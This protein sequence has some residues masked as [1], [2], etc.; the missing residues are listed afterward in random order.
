LLLAVL[1]ETQRKIK[2]PKKIEIHY[3]VVD[4]KIYSR[5]AD[6]TDTADDIGKIEIQNISSVSNNNSKNN[7]EGVFY[8]GYY[9]DIHWFK[10]GTLAYN[11]N[12]FGDLA[13]YLFIKTFLWGCFG[14]FAFVLFVVIAVFVTKL[15]S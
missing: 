4:G 12:Y 13:A 8:H 2:M 11:L 6:A 7:S 5:N 14:I 3:I 1:A 9:G 10:K 15:F